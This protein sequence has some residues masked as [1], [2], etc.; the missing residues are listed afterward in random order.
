M[1]VCVC[2]DVLTDSLR[3]L[4]QTGVE[5]TAALRSPNIAYPN[6]IIGVTGNALGD[7]VTAFLAA[8]ADMVLAKPLRPAQLRHLLAYITGHGKRSNPGFKLAIGAEGVIRTP[9]EP[10]RLSQHKDRQQ[11]QEQQ[12]IR[13]A[14]NV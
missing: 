10:N 12:D 7:D 14:D 9:V 6:L 1:C 2:V 5:A 13:L 4:M 3:A 11:E 8:G